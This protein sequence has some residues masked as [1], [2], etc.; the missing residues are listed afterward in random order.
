MKDKQNILDKGHNDGNDVF[1]LQSWKEYDKP[2]KT[3]CM[4][5]FERPWASCD[6][7][8]SSQESRTRKTKQYDIKNKD[9]VCIKTI[10][11]ESQP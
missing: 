3:T 8:Y 9:Q 7:F 1:D 11:S 2:N 6:S 10:M 4:E 5:G